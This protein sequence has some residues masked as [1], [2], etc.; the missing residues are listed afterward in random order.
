M[1]NEIKTIIHNETHYLLEKELGTNFIEY[2]MAVNTDRAI[3]DAKTGLKP[4]ATRILWGAYRDGFTTSK[5]HVKAARIVGNVMA[6]LHPHGDSSI[7]GALVRLSQNWVMRYPLIDWHGS[8]GNQIGDGPAA[9][10]YT[11]ARLSKLAEEGMM[12]GIKKKNVPFKLTFDE[13]EEEPETLPAIFPNLL[14]NPNTGIGVA[15]ATGFACHNL[16]EVAQ[17]IY[18]Y[19]DGKE[20][21]LPGPDFPTGGIIIN[22]NDISK[23]MAT[24]KG[25]VK[26]RSKYVIED[27]AIIFYEIPYGKTVEGLISE[28][29]T[30]CDN[31][32]I[33]EISNVR[34]ET[35]KKGVRIVVECA[36]DANFKS[37][38][39]K[40][41]AKTNLQSSFSYNQVALVDKTP[42]LLNLKDCIKIYV[43]HNIECLIKET[44][45]D[46][47]KAKARLEI[48]DGLLKALEDIDNII[49]LIKKSESSAKAKDNLIITYN[50]TENQ[51][52]AIVDMKLGRLAGLE[53]IELQNEQTG[54]NNTIK[55]LN[56]LLNSDELQLKEIR[57]RLED[58]VKKYGDTRKTELIQLSEDPK[59][60]II[61]TVTPEDCV[62]VISESHLIKRIPSKSYRAQ[63]RGGVGVKNNDDITSFIVKT[64]TIDTLMVFSSEGKM[65]RLIV[66]DIPVGTNS[67]KGV[68][69]SS[70]INFETKEIPMAYASL[71][72]GSTAK[73]VF[74]V[75]KNGIIKKVPLDEYTQTKRAAG[76]KAIALREG[77]ALAAVTFIEEEE[78]LLMT[79]NGMIIRFETKNMPLSSRTAQGVKGMN[80]NEND[81]IL[82]CLP[83]KHNTDNL[84]VLSIDGYGKKV[85]LN[86]FN[87][88]NRGGKGVKYSNSPVAGVALI[89]DTD[90]LLVIGN[91]NSIRISTE[92]LPLLTKTSL[93]NNIIKNNNIVS[94][95]KI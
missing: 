67:S 33:P 44:V 31:G 73:Y 10:R 95:S 62:V 25:S 83:I 66:D 57:E 68:P 24:G 84:A 91:K 30:V 61:E 19:M 51:A 15:M 60:K 64:N 88:Q 77:D 35:N 74:F 20:P 5:P 22:K 28:I 26:I 23:I 45:F 48:V 21:M 36:K 40:L 32:D 52:K 47:N 11:E 50:F 17:A 93:G 8:N 75:T 14:C 4:V 79:K 70:L 89:D 71:Y 94:V 63:K 78:M 34:D 58:I 1:S 39:S 56:A 41:F 59:E 46:L 2:A 16:N 82:T 27:N 76:V 6:S 7:Y 9:M 37:V 81:A 87:T 92:E 43:N 29:G 42:L 54:L 69:V 86:E 13:T 18:D 65:Y 3:P 53:R 80:L 90:N 85:S 49:A 38:I 55:K 12:Q 72:H